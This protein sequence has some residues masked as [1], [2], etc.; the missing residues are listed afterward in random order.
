MGLLGGSS[1]QIPDLGEDEVGH[2]AELA[3]RFRSLHTLDLRWKRTRFWHAL[4]LLLLLMLWL[5]LLSVVH[6]DCPG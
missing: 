2:A 1:L 4:L 6:R 3:H 5:L